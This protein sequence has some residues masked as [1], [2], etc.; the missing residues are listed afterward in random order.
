M[1]LMKRMNRMPRILLATAGI[2]AVASA[3]N[4][5]RATLSEPV[6]PEA[7]G[8]QLIAS[9]TN[10][11]GGSVRFQFPRDGADATRDSLHVVLSGLDSLG[12]GFWTAWIGDSLGS[13]FV[14]ATG[15]L[16]S[17]RTDTTFDADGNPQGT[18]TTIPI[19]TVSSFKNGGPNQEFTW[20]FSR[21]GAGLSAS[22]S[23]QTFL[24]TIESTDGASS[25]GS[26]RVLWARRGE[27]SNVPAAG[28]AFRNSTI[29]F[30]NWGPTAQEQFLFVGTARGRA[31]IQ[32]TLLIAVDS[33]MPRPPLGYYYAMWA[34]KRIPGETTGWDTIFLGEQTSPFPRR[35]L[36]QYN[37]DSVVT[38]PEVVLNV[39]RS[40]IAGSV[41]FDARDEPGL[42]NPGVDRPACQSYGCPFLGYNEFWV[43]IEPKDG[44]RGRMGAARILLASIPTIVGDGAR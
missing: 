16:S 10:L 18:P 5:E 4:D 44:I 7:F 14:R 34:H 41:R 39:P 29:R 33:S 15:T 3:C 11:P 13:S 25:P 23:M 28:T 36:S 38:D 2:F 30:G 1:E 37:A 17:E 9:A 26:R 27:G 31:A 35:H 20:A 43:T 8:F 12:A 6:A 21:T 42:L 32:Q 24:V 22:D 40:I 19:G